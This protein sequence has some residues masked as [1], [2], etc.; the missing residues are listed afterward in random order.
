MINK[1]PYTDFHELNLDWFLRQFKALKDDWT[2]L[3]ADNAEFKQTLTESFDTLDH[4]VQTF[5]DFVTNYFDNLDVQTEINNKLNDMAADGTLEQLLQPFVDAAVPP[6]VTAWLDANVT[7]VG[8]AVTVDS[9]LTLT[10]SAADARVTGNRITELDDLVE[11]SNTM[12]LVWAQGYID[13]TGN[14]GNSNNYIRSNG[15]AFVRGGTVIRMSLPSNL[16][17]RACRYSS[18]SA[19]GFIDRDPSP[20]EAHVEYVP[21]DTYYRFVVSNSGGGSIAPTAGASVTISRIRNVSPQPVYPIGLHVDPEA[22]GVLNMIRRARQYTDIEWT[23][24]VDLPRFIRFRTDG[25]AFRSQGMF[26][27]GVKYKGMP[28]SSAKGTVATQFG[29]TRYIPGIDIG[30]E[31]FITAIESENSIVSNESGYDEG[32]LYSTAYGSTCCGLISYA[33]G[34]PW[35]S[36]ADINSMF[37]STITTRGTINSGLDLDLIQLGDIVASPDHVAMITD[38]IRDKD[39]HN[40]FFEV[41]ENTTVGGLLN[42]ANKDGVYGGHAWRHGWT[43]SDF[44]SYYSGYKAGQYTN[45]RYVTYTPTPYV[46]TGDELDRMQPADLPCVPYCG[47]NFAYKAGNIANTRIL[48]RTSDF[49][50]LYVYKDGSLFNTFPV[51]AGTEYVTVGFSAAG[52][53]NAF[54]CNVSGG[55][56]QNQTSSCHWTVT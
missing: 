48:I 19:A 16:L 43:A 39:G 30:F 32:I 47:E 50:H 27:A 1:Y 18:G 56:I 7:P 34:I 9:S 52:T 3:A 44:E 28:Y 17:I 40:I 42:P 37:G 51:T 15:F 45:R 13:A 33:M 36:T 55:V 24:A 41:S 10:G 25:T 38:I 12:A 8:S 2:A 21:V 29:Y 5:T 54:L 26:K 14:N 35:T 31:T 6:A 46:N 53:Y 11:T 20:T 49:T 22:E 4:T 23:P